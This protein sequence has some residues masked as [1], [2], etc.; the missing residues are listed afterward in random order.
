MNQRL[1]K[2]NQLQT[3]FRNTPSQ[4]LRDSIQYHYDPEYDPVLVAKP[5]QQLESL[6]LVD[7][8]YEF[9]REREQR[10][11]DRGKKIFVSG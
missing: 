2:L 4:K 9:K 7:T 5:F 1:L 3:F 10:L 8:T 6:K 11:L